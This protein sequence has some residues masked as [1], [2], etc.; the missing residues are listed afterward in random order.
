MGSAAHLLGCACLVPGPTTVEP[1]G[2][3]S[4]A[5]RTASPPPPGSERHAKQE[6]PDAPV[7]I[8][9]GA[10]QWPPTRCAHWRGLLH[11]HPG[12]TWGLLHA[13]MMPTWSRG[14]SSHCYADSKQALMRRPAAK[15]VPCSRQGDVTLPQRVMISPCHSGLH[16]CPL[17]SLRPWC[18][19]DMPIMV[20][21]PPLPS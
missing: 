11:C 2:M 17:Q 20:S 8:G 1:S 4:N 13:C 14:G 18:C 16:A 12:C 21:Y 15:A 9:C 7:C 19:I 5:Q 10:S 3:G 6:V